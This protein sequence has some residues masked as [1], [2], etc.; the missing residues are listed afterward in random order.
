MC[1]FTF[2]YYRVPR[3]SHITS[4]ENTQVKEFILL[5]LTS[6]L[7]LQVPLV[8]MFPLVYLI[9][10]IGKLGMIRLI[11]LDS[12]LHTPKYILFPQYPVSG[13]FLLLLSNHS[14]GHGWVLMGDKVISYTACATQMFVFVVFA[15]G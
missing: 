5:G 15:T 13:G 12:R 11:L 4:M 8:I 14:Q 3:D 2:L 1:S 7:E 9:T 6:V 10:L